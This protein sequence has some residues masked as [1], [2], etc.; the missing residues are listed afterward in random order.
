VAVC[1]IA[2]RLIKV[3]KKRYKYFIQIL[4]YSKLTLGLGFN[5]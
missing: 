3:N 5:F 4:C 2:E 1:P